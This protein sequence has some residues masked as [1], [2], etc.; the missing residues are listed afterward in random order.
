MCTPLT[1]IGDSLDKAVALSLT[2]V[3]LLSLQHTIEMQKDNN[4]IENVK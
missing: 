1:G 3:I 2:K 4:E